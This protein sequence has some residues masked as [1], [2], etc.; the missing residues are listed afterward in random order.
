MRVQSFSSI[1]LAGVLACGGGGDGGGGNNPVLVLAKATSSGDN[2]TGTVAAALAN[3]FCA[4][5]TSDGAA[6]AGASVTWA[7][8]SGGSMSAGSTTTGADGTACS[9]LTLGQTAGAQTATA[10]SAGANGS[11]LTFN[12]TANADAAVDLQK[13]G[14]D[15][16]QGN[17]NTQLAE[18]VSVQALDQ[19]GN[20]VPNVSVDWAATGAAVL[21]SAGN[22][23]GFGVSNTTVTLGGTAGA[24]VI[25]ATAIGLNGSPQTFNATANNPPPPPSAI[26]ITVGSPGNN[27]TPA[28]DTVAA[29]GTVTWTWSTANHS[30]TTTGPT[31]FTSDPAGIVPSIPHTY[32]PITFNTPGTY[33]YYCEAHGSPGNPPTGMSG[34]IVVQ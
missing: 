22:T 8:S 25:T 19:F 6:K 20:G 5:L 10:T 4:K 31:S 34:T 30:V 26:T 24:I 33:Y 18:Q 3:S 15:N 23:D 2:Q 21:P 11:P 13:N 32:G 7:T 9:K 12:A 16:Q 1:L 28:V 29:G 14:G 17:I 27:F